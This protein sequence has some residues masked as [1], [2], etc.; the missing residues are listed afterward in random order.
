MSRPEDAGPEMMANWMRLWLGL[1]GASERI[2]LYY[3]EVTGEDRGP[4]RDQ[5]TGGDKDAAESIL[6]RHIPVE[7]FFAQTINSREPLDSKVL[8]ALMRSAKGAGL[9]S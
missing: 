8:I 5:R 2:H 3:A 9:C 4:E 6:I 1:G 7:D